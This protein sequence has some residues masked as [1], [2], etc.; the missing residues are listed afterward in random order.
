MVER[1]SFSE[2]RITSVTQ[3]RDVFSLTREEAFRRRDLQANPGEDISG[4][5]PPDYFYC[6]GRDSSMEKRLADWVRGDLK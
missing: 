3:F 6:I 4:T 2:H 5:P 1:Y